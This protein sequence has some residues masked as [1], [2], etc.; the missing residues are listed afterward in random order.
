MLCL[1]GAGKNETGYH[2]LFYPRLGTAMTKTYFNATMLMQLLIKIQ[3][4]GRHKHS[5]HSARS[6]AHAPA[7][8]KARK[9]NIGI[10]T[11]CD[12]RKTLP[13]KMKIPPNI[14]RVFRY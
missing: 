3:N 1:E 8:R 11:F 7:A 4:L 6:R 5:A 13:P 14:G 10:F 2:G 9:A 12:D